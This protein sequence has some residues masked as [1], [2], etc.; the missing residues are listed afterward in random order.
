[1]I[2]LIPFIFD[3]VLPCVEDICYHHGENDTVV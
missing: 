3:I 1:M 2:L